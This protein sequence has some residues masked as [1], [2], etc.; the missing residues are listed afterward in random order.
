[1]TVFAAGQELI[2]DLVLPGEKRSDGV[3]RF[4]VTVTAIEP[5][6]SAT[7]AV[8]HGPKIVRIRSTEAGEIAIFRDGREATIDLIQ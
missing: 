1:M 2:I 7:V 6:L 8:A 3:N 5:D 4:A